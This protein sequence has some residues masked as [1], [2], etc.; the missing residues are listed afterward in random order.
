M[1]LFTTLCVYAFKIILSGHS[2][3]C[4]SF[5]KSLKVNRV[6][7]CRCLWKVPACI[8]LYPGSFLLN[9]FQERIGL[10][11]VWFVVKS[12]LQVGCAGSKFKILCMFTEYHFKISAVT[13]VK[14]KCSPRQWL[15]SIHSITYHIVKEG[16]K[17]STKY[18][19]IDHNTRMVVNNVS[20]KGQLTE[21]ISWH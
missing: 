4:V 17:C 11:V 8:A 16:V 13:H 1:N 21:L 3:Y 18:G 2:L 10:I 14:K 6:S 19:Q 7:W 15:H 12:I 9:T 5:Y 20:I